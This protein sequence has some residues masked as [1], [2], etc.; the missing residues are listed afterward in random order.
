MPD[1]V[2]LFFVDPKWLSFNRREVKAVSVLSY[3]CSCCSL[4]TLSVVS[5]SCSCCSVA[6]VLCCC[7]CFSS[8]L[9]ALL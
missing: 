1:T 4:S 5:Y 2:E 8:S 6:S 7:S 9:S 3:S